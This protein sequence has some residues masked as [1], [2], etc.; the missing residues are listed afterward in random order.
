MSD[1]AM[2]SAGILIVDDTIANL[3]LLTQMLSEQGYRVRPVPSGER[4]LEAA[5]LNPPDLILLDIRMPEMDGYQVCAALR[6]NAAT[7]D[8]P[9]VFI[10][11]MDEVED[12]VRAFEVGGVDYITK[13]F[14]F[15]EVLARV[16]THLTLSQLQRELERHA[17]N[18]EELVVEKMQE[19]DQERAKALQ[20]DKMASL[21]ELATGIAHEL[22]QP[23]TAITFE[24][25]YLRKI[26]EKADAESAALADLLPPAELGDI[27]K[28]LLEDVQRCRRIVDHLRTFGRLSEEHI[29]DVDLNTPIQDSLILVGMRLRDHNVT[30]NLHLAP[31]L[32]LI[33]ADPYRLEQVFL[34]LM[35]N[36]EH[37]MTAMAEARAGHPKVLDITTGVDADYV[38]A[39]VQDTGGGIPEAIQERIFD[40]FF[41]TK[42]VGQ[43]T[44]LG[45]SISH[46]IIREF[47]GEITFESVPDEGTI[48]TLRFPLADVEES[49]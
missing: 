42:P 40:P 28:N 14:Q 29:E 8:I 49:A 23:L 4:A 2:D 46:D 44:G 32:P 34:N 31:D 20:M 17:E 24:A 48:F 10:S 3:R 21:G 1:L 9:I 6:A 41:T 45:L 37:A 33:R 11:A 16:R 13:P 15:E 47:G 27:G 43:G 12:K 18:L 5:R 39:T 19:L 30:L 22:N 38:W 7:R 26:A 36:A 25:D 35:N